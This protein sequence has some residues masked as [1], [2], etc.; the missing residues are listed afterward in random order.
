MHRD[1]SRKPSGTT[2]RAHLERHAR[3]PKTE[4]VSV[5]LTR[6]FAEMI[7]GVNLQH[8]SVGDR[9]ELSRRDAEMLIAE[10]W[11]EKS[12]EKPV[13]VLPTRSIA[14]DSHRR[15]RKKSKT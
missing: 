13:R 4:E 5:R 9:L 11:A 6:K 8:A 2:G 3:S 14:A 12:E 7:D 15:S 10:G 1:N